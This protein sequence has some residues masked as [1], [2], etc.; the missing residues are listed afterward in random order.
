[1][2]QEITDQII[3]KLNSLGGDLTNQLNALVSSVN[4]LT[5]ENQQRIQEIIKLN[6]WGRIRELEI[7]LI[8]SHLGSK[9]QYFQDL[10]V[11]THFNHKCGGFFV[12]F[13]ACD[14]ITGSNTFLL[15]KKYGWTGILAEPSKVWWSDLKKNRQVNIDFRCVFSE[16]NLKL[17]FSET[18]DPML[19]TISKHISSDFH[20]GTRIAEATEIYSV[21]TVS[22]NDLLAHYQAPFEIDYLSI[23]TEGSEYEI[24][25]TFDFK[26]YKIKIITVE[27]NYN[28]ND[29]AKINELLIANN[30]EICHQGLTYAD[31]WY[32]LK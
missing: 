24:L 28:E 22:L 4:K 29:R 18:A 19:S 21:T 32:K 6:D 16:S 14:G 9:S 13:G 27:H 5:I 25:S 1:M 3:K 15:E 12:E 20:A 23:D 11:T 31:D 30:Y 2:R 17:E 7:N 10:F 8:K 26:R